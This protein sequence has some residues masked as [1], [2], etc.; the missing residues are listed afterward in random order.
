MKIAVSFIK[1]K[2]S[3]FDT[4]DKI[5]NTDADYLHVDVMDGKFVSNTECI[6][7][8]VK[9]ALNKSNKKLDV[10]LMVDSPI[11]YIMDYKNLSPYSITFHSEINKN[12]TDLIDLIHSYNIKAG[13][14]IKPKT[15][16]ESIE[17]YLGIID[18]V[19]IMSVEPGLGGQKFM[20]SQIYKIEILKR[21][22][23]ENNYNY[24][25]S[26]DGGI[27]NETINKVK[28]VDFVISGS[29]ICMN[30][31]YQERINILRYGRK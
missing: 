6:Y 29:Y 20:D 4:I 14:S 13:L 22:R 26:I 27:N 5:N 30:D 1:S 8:E 3:L 28:D 10:H 25:I 16:I 21:L 12:I 18:N 19:L 31:D 24:T 9:D 23:Q 17:K 11:D 15:S 2:Y 7:N